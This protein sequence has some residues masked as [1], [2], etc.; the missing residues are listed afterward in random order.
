VDLSEVTETADRPEALD[1]LAGGGGRVEELAALEGRLGRDALSRDQMRGIVQSAATLLS[2]FYVHLPQKRTLYASD[3]LGQLGVLETTLRGMPPGVTDERTENDFHLALTEV[4]TSLRDC[5]TNYILP[6]PYRRRVAFLPFLIERC[7][8]E[9]ESQPVHV[10]TKVH[11]AARADDFPDPREDGSGRMVVTHWNGVEIGRAVAM[12]GALNAGGNADARR[13]RGLKRLTFR[14]L[15]LGAGPAEDWVV[16]TYELDGRR[17]HR[18]FPWLVVERGP[19]GAGDKVARG[20]DVEGEWLRRLERDLFAREQAAGFVVR[21]VSDGFAHMRIHAFEHADGYERFLAGAR[22][23]LLAAEAGGVRRLAID[24]RGNPGG[25]IRAAEG[26][27]QMLASEPLERERMQFLN[28]PDA[29]DL[30]AAFARSEGD[31]ER[32]QANLAEAFATGAPYISS[33]T[34]RLR[35]DDPPVDEERAF[36][37]EVVLIVDAITYSAGDVFAA[38]WQDNEI[39]PIVGT[40]RRT[41]GGGGNGWTY[42]MIRE[43]AGSELLRPVPYGATFDLAIRR[44]LR[45]RERAGVGLEDAGVDVGAEVHEMT[46][47]DVL[48]RN[49]DLLAFAA[50]ALD[51]SSR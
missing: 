6:E 7:R 19:D 41:G 45:V 33:P 1:D 12:N 18:R 40:A 9:R 31:E 32:F 37:G 43:L 11:P 50:R 20:V 17:Q 8:M 48:G 26:L 5:H 46:L 13:A 14:W 16:L 44:M 39:G 25:D 23:A 4:F 21:P 34:T 47:A 15:G 29:S 10:I 28:T 30:A 36:H 35:R 27:L 24:V 42:D 38:G 22:E 49:D 2:R 3:P 51:V